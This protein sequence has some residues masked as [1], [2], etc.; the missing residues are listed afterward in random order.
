MKKRIFFLILPIFAISACQSGRV[1][2]GTQGSSDGNSSTNSTESSEA[3]RVG[4]ETEF[5]ASNFGWKAMIPQSWQGYEQ[6]DE[7]D[8]TSSYVVVSNYEKSASLKAKK[9]DDYR[10]IIVKKIEKSEDESMTSVID[11]LLEDKKITARKL[12]F[13]KDYQGNRIEFE[14]SKS[15]KGLMTTFRKDNNVWVLTYAEV[16]ELDG[17][18]LWVYQRLVETFTIL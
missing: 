13:T 3:A 15:N 2:V 6:V 4:P 18:T 12:L 9:E 8:K 14:D 11:S 16:G 1:D 7:T 10:E 17:Q 5:D